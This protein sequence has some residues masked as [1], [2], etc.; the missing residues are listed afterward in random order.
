MAKELPKVYDPKEVESRIYEQWETNGCF[1]GHRDPNKKPFTIVM[2]PP[3]VTGQLHMGHA[4]DCHPPGHPHPLQAD[5]GLRRSV[6]SR[7]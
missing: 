4:M 2:P 7:H 5:A 6:G 3:N 1:R